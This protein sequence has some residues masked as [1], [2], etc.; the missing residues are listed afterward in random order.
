MRE[1]QPTAS[2][3]G[4]ATRA[5][6]SRR[7][8]RIRSPYPLTPRNLGGRFAFPK[9]IRTLYPPGKRK[10]QRPFLFSLAH[11][12]PSSSPA[13]PTK[14]ESTNNPPPRAEAPVRTAPNQSPANETPRPTRKN[15]QLTKNSVLQPY[16]RRGR[17]NPPG[18][19]TRVTR[20]LGGY[21]HRV[22][23]RAPSGKLASMKSKTP[24]RRFYPNHLESRGLLLGT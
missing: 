11:L 22:R 12:G 23:S 15:T 8:T 1:G 10:P 7:G 20:G 13:G 3:S 9:R 2:I 5:T 21:T 24:S 6:A 17:Y 18:D 16:P 14:K 19:S 4:P